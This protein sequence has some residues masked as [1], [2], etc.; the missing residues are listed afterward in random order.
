MKKSPAR[1]LVEPQGR[2]IS[3]QPGE[4]LR[5]ALFREGV[6]F[7]C[8]GKGRCGGCRIRLSEGELAPSQLEKDYFSAAEINEGWRFACRAKPCGDIRLHIEQW[9]TPILDGHQEA[10]FPSREGY[11]IAVDL[12]TT[13][14]VAQ[15]L[16]LR[17]GEVLGVGKSLNPQGAHG[18]DLMSR[19]EYGLS[20]QGFEKL[21]Q[22]VRACIGSLVQ[23][24]VVS[25]KIDTDSL[26]R[27]VVVGNTVM[28]H[29]FCG[30][31]IRSL[32]RVPF[33]PEY[34]MLH[35]MT[36]EA[37]DWHSVGC[38][39]VWVLPCLG[40]F[41]GGD[42]LAGILSTKMHQR[43]EIT[44]LVDL[45]TN[46]EIVIGNRDRMLCASTAAGP[47]FEGGG[48]K[49]GMYATGG[50]IDAVDLEGDK[51]VCHVIGNQKA[52]GICG[53]GLVDAVASG[54]DLGWIHCSG[55]IVLEE[56]Q[57][58]LRHTVHLTQGDIR[59]LQLAKGAI[60]AGVQV[61]IEKF[62]L[63]KEDIG[64][65]FLAGAFGNSVNVSSA[66]RIGLL[67]FTE[68]KIEPVGNS[69]LLGAKLA[70][71]LD[72]L[73]QEN[74][75]KLSGELASIQEKIEHISLGESREFQEYFI[76]GTSFPEN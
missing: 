46:G 45:G 55:R 13:T 8:G 58:S 32:S 14:I 41:V 63:D 28:Y 51:L 20:C 6:E 10:D 52:K 44:V 5:D 73:D 21:V 65:V 72:E 56:K 68:D 76:E 27:V 66:I 34:K 47:A 2:Q 69:A 37:L 11:G 31:D 4:S 35:K 1:I 50:A 54:L 64:T 74:V 36:V 42:I 71:W 60:C 43:S 29:L 61:L 7:P 30:F 49:M 15:L 25:N 24:L 57:I 59:Q 9:D 38:P 16:D 18:A 23:E 17:D 39:L 75:D 70:L 53:S 48:V 62:G 19:I 26:N 22:S 12:G 67:P 33:E 40:G 3:L